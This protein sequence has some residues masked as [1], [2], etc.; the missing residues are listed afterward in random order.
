MKTYKLN[1]LTGEQIAALTKRPAINYEKIFSVV[2]PILK[3]IKQNGIAA[4]IKYAE[5]LDGFKGVNIKVAEDEFNEAEKKLAP[6]IK[7]A[8]ET[9]ASNIKKFHSVQFPKPYKIETMPG[10]FCS[11]E[12]R[13]IESAGLYIPGGSA[14]LPSTLLMLAI[15]A[16]IAGCKRVAAFSPA[17]N[18]SVNLPL[19]YAAKVCGINEFYKIGGAQ[20]VGLMAYGDEKVPKV[21]KIFGPGNQYVTA[22]KILASID[23]EGSSIDMPAGPSEVLVIADR[24]ASPAFVA[25]DLLSQAEHGPDS[26]AILVTDS[27]NLIDSVNEELQKQLNKLPRKEIA[28]QSLKHS[29]YVLVDKPEEAVSFSNNYAPEHLI[30]NVD[31][32][33]SYISKIENAGSVFLGRYSPESVGDYASGTNHSLPTYGYAKTFGGVNVEMF[34]KPV[35][36]QQLTKEGLQGIAETV[37]TL[38]A[39]EGLDAHKNAVS[40]RLK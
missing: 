33:D 2:R 27:E 38:A 23:P 13:A 20:A 9:A 11:R 36:F 4:A 21:N 7:N 5:K 19:L 15:P 14:V 24:S 29:F 18:N 40:I 37:E 30:I 10:V 16:K 34:M 39:V 3:D 32:P 25:S 12:Y 31:E 35:T 1:N 26:Q 6:E 17:K 28:V 8:I 22:A